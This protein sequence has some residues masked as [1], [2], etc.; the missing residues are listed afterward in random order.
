MVDRDIEEPLNL[1]RMQIDKQR[2]VRAG[3]RQQV[4]NQLARDRHARPVFAVLPCIPV[5]RHNHRNSACR[6]APQR[7][8]HNQQF[9]QVAVDRVAGGLDQ[10]Y[11]HASHIFKELKMG[12]AVGE[13]L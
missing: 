6:G 2:S 3:C 13:P 1:R 8:H 11:I 7:I 9:D 10:K 5:V 12:L 4:C